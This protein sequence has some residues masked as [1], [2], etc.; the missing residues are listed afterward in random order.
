MR[1]ADGHRLNTAPSGIRMKW[2][3]RRRTPLYQRAKIALLDDLSLRFWGSKLR[4]DQGVNPK[5]SARE[6]IL[7]GFNFYGRHIK[8]AQ[9]Q[10][11]DHILGRDYINI[12]KELERKRL[13][14]SYIGVHWGE[15]LV[16]I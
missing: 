3:S 8:D 1:L 13:Y 10:K 11:L 5:Q 12:L 7:M 2:L 4:Y 15:M 9:A 16:F 6:K 14:K